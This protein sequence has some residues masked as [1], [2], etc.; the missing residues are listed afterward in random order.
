[1]RNIGNFKCKRIYKTF[2]IGQHFL[3]ITRLQDWTM[4]SNP[5]NIMTYDC[6][7]LNFKTASSSLFHQITSKPTNLSIPVVFICE[8]VCFINSLFQFQVFDN[9][10]KE[11]QKIIQTGFAIFV[12]K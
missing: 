4:Q 1:M 5:V 3:F 12:V 9:E 10:Q 11:M 6:K 7:E 2:F 8:C